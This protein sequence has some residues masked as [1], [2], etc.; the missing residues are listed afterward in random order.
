MQP[1]E[2]TNL[3]R[4]HRRCIRRAHG[5]D[6]CPCA[7]TAAWSPPSTAT[8]NGGRLPDSKV[9]T[10]SEPACDLGARGRADPQDD[11]IPAGSLF[12]WRALAVFEPVTDLWLLRPDGTNT[13]VPSEA[14]PHPGGRWR[15]RVVAAHARDAGIGGTDPGS[16]VVHVDEANRV[17]ADL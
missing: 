17:R 8:T 15:N 9:A 16:Q 1:H 14:R 13:R 6:H 7:I 11:V 3:R 10:P 12:L 5:F 4:T 2:E